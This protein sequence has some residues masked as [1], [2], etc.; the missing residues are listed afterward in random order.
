[1]TWSALM[2]Q[3]ADTWEALAGDALARARACF[4]RG[5]HQGAIGASSEALD[6]LIG[7][8]EA[9]AALAARLYSQRGHSRFLQR[10][11][12]GAIEDYS[13]ALEYDPALAEAYAYRGLIYY[14]TG[15][16]IGA[17]ADLST[18]IDLYSR[19]AAATDPQ[20]RALAEAHINR[21]NAQY[22]RRDYRAAESDYAAALAL[23]PDLVDALIYRGV[24]RYQEGNSA[25]AYSDYRQALDHPAV[26]SRQRAVI[27]YNRGLLLREQGNLAGA[28]ADYSAALELQPNDADCLMNRGNVHAEQGNLAG[29]LADYSAA[30]RLNPWLEDGF[31]IRGMARL[32]ARDLAGA[33]EDFSRAIKDNPQ[34]TNVF[35]N[36]G[37]AHLQLGDL[38]R[39]IEDFTAELAL[40]APGLKGRVETREKRAEIYNNRGLAYHYQGDL[41]A[42]I[43]DYGRSLQQLQLTGGLDAIGERMASTLLNR[44]VAYCDQPRGQLDDSARQEALRAAA[45]DLEQALA[46]APDPE[47]AAAARDR[48][49]DVQRLLLRLEIRD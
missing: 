41:A 33:I 37:C 9:H 3:R 29:A 19:D 17:V 8:D 15:K 4:E 44:G 46:L 7:G 5:D 40:R 25:G 10:D 6:T 45:A 12:P 43:E 36:R 28:L 22:Q 16:S 14:Q 38:A 2:T 35:F 21:G 11:L 42:A 47:L 48:L 1:L 49:H 34:A 13:R 27:H 18:A 39:A 31:N 23:S 26:T 32:A 24:A 20:R 30:L